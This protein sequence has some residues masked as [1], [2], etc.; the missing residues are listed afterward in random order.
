MNNVVESIERRSKFGIKLGLENI[1]LVLND[2]GNPHESLKIIHIGGTNGKGSVCAMLEQTLIDSGYTVAKYTSP[3]LLSIHEMFIVNKIA[4][5]E[6]M[7]LKCY[8]QVNAV[9]NKLGI[10]L[11]QYELTTTIFFLYANFKNVE[12][13]ICEVGLGGRLD[14]TNVVNPLITI[15][16][17]ISLDHTN[18]LGNTIEQIATEKAGIIKPNCPLFTSESNLQALNIFNQATKLITVVDDQCKYKLD[19]NSF[20]TKIIVDQT[21]YEFNLFGSHQVANFLL[22]KKVL[23]YMG[24]NNEQIAISARKCSHQARLEKLTHN[25]VFDGAH[26]VASAQALASSLKNI[27]FQINIIFSILEDKQIIEVV[28]E[29]KKISS[30]LTFVTLN[31]ERTLSVEKFNDLNITDVKVANTISECI[32]DNQLNLI[33]GTFKLYKQVIDYINK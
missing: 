12:Y 8:E 14:A 13:A 29:F 7:L 19:F 31:E 25:I 3:Y 32:I 24:I 20:T 30:N 28:D 16:T 4:I 10:N 9:E 18:L 33:C 27:D 6:K 11:T 5:D 21:K 22:A 2:L 1:K 15:I 23:N 26:N 17:N